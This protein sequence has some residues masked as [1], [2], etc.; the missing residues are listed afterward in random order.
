MFLSRGNWRALEARETPRAARITR[1]ITA[2]ERRRIGRWSGRREI[3]KRKTEGDART[4]RSGTIGLYEGPLGDMNSAECADGS[5]RYRPPEFSWSARLSHRAMNPIDIGAPVRFVNFS[6]RLLDG[7][8]A[9]RSGDGYVS[10][11]T[12]H[13]TDYVS[14]RSHRIPPLIFGEHREIGDSIR[15]I[16]K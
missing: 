16:T 1:D 5:A 14:C 12:S 11:R 4:K 10:P 9:I 13:W 6:K 3:E 15:L 7:T 2:A 8:R